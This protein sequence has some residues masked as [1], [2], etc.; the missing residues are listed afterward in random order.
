[1]HSDNLE[2]GKE[3]ECQLEYNERSDD[4]EAAELKW[5]QEALESHEHCDR[6][7]EEAFEGQ[8]RDHFWELPINGLLLL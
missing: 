2:D 7:D 8:E 3:A 4:I 6:D 1:M 5:E